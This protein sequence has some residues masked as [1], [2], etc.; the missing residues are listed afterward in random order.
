MKEKGPALPTIRKYVIVE[1]FTFG[2]DPLHFLQI[3]VGGKEK[4]IR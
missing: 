3:E 2:V 1:I 4:Y